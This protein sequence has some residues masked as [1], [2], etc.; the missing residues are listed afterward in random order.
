M[1]ESLILNTPS[2]VTITWTIPQFP[3]LCCDGVV[4]SDILNSL[5]LDLLNESGKYKHICCWVITITKLT[6]VLNKEFFCPQGHLQ[7]YEGSL[8]GWYNVR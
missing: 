6:N 3:Q 5:Q 8:S 1:Q 7:M 4:I 2:A